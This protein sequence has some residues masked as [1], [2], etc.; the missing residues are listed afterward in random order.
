IFGAMEPSDAARVL[1]R[2]D[3]AEVRL[4]LFH[5]S[6][7]K[8]AAILGQ[9]EPTRAARLSQG[10]M[11]EG[12]A[13]QGWDSTCWRPVP[14]GRSRRMSPPGTAAGGRGERRTRS[15]RPTPPAPWPRAGAGCPCPRR[16]R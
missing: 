15:G 9:L 1:E 10:A 2:L 8:V 4:I 13:R 16:R 14:P 7:R 5:L 12:G 3:D 6:D 11:A